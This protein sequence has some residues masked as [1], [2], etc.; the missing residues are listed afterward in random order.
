MEEKN[1]SQSD[2]FLAEFALLVIVTKSHFNIHSLSRIVRQ[3]L[4]IL[5]ITTNKFAKREAL[6]AYEWTSI[7]LKLAR[8]NNGHF[9]FGTARW[10]SDRFNVFHNFFSF[11]NFAKDDVSTIEPRCLYCGYEKLRSVPGFK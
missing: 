3:D 11:Q 4:D 7:T 8:I 2:W 9:L 6:V 1:A 10:R 5:N